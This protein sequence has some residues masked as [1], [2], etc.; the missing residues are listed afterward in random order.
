MKKIIILCLIVL[1]PTSTMFAEFYFG[2]IWK[3]T[4][5]TIQPT[6]QPTT[7]TIYSVGYE[8]IQEE[9]LAKTWRDIIDKFEQGS[10]LLV[11]EDK[12]PQSAYFFKET[13]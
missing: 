9:K 8:D 7:P 2:N 6:I 4:K 1:V 12:A 11:D 5:P 10:S 13:A 3:T